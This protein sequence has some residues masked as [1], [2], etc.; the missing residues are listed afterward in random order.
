MTL[1]KARA[2]RAAHV[3][4]EPVKAL[5]LQMALIVI[6]ESAPLKPGSRRQKLRLPA[7]SPYVRMKANAALLYQLGLALGRIEGRKA[8]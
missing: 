4:G 8:A 3:Q 5:D 1:D 7:L 6:A 2:I